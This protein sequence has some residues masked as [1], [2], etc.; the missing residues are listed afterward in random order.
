MFTDAG[1]WRIADGKWEMENG[2]W[3]SAK[4][5]IT[6]RYKDTKEGLLS[7]FL[8]LFAGS[9]LERSLLRKESRAKAPV[10]AHGRAPLLFRSA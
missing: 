2:K 3:T 8:V 7:F 5:F 1:G 9:S 4:F 6:Q 10:G